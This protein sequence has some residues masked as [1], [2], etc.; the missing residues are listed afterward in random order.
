MKS[1]LLSRLHFLFSRLCC[2]T[3]ALG[4]WTAARL[5]RF[6]DKWLFGPFVSPI[7]QIKVPFRRARTGKT[8]EKSHSTELWSAGASEWSPNVWWHMIWSLPWHEDKTQSL[9]FPSDPFS[10]SPLFL[11]F[12][13]LL[14]NYFSICSRQSLMTHEM[15]SRNRKK[16]S[17]FIGSES[18]AGNMKPTAKF[19]NYYSTQISFQI[20]I[21]KKLSKWNRCSVLVATA[22]N[23]EQSGRSQKNFSQMIDAFLNEEKLFWFK[24]CHFSL[25]AERSF[26]L[27][28][29]SRRRWENKEKFLNFKFS[30]CGAESS[31]SSSVTIWLHFLIPFSS[32]SEAN[33]SSHYDEGEVRVGWEALWRRV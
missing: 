33:S 32:D 26:R 16:F 12:S 20:A 22:I 19:L 18:W 2:S 13:S 29:S 14:I 28:W 25:K 3:I 24:F 8:T 5:F 1:C 27:K 21:E 17:L 15:T 9:T 7:A 11:P 6:N 10:L 31:S 4:G 30:F 23:V